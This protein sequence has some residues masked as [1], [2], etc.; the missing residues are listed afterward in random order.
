MFYNII[1]LR[2][3][4]NL[5]GYNNDLIYKIRKDMI[6]FKNITCDAPPNKINVVIMGY[7]TW[8]SLPKK[9]TPLPNRINVVLTKNHLYNLKNTVNSMDDE[10]KRLVMIRNN[11]GAVLNELEKMP[12]IHDI[13]VIGGESIFRDA[14]NMNKVKRIY[15]TEVQSNKIDEIE[16]MEDASY[17]PYL[18]LS[19]YNIINTS[20]VITVPM[21]SS[22]FE[23]DPESKKIIKKE[24][25]TN[26]DYTNVIYESK[27]YD[28]IIKSLEKDNA[29]NVQNNEEMQYLNLLKEVITIGHK[30]QTRNAITYS[31]FGKRMEFDLSDGRIPVLTTKRIAIK[32]CTKELLWF[33]SGDTN[34]N[35]LFE[36]NVHIWDG[37]SSREYLDSIGLTE[38]KEGDLGPVY[39]FQWRHSGAKYTTCDAD[40]EGQGIDQL[41]NCINLLKND[42]HSRRNILSAWNPSDMSAMALPPCHIMAQWYV[43]DGNKL[44]LQMY[45]RSGD[46]FL[47]VPFNIFSYSLLLHMMAHVCGMK[48]GR[49]IHIIGD[50]HAYDIHIDAINEQLI[51]EPQ[52]F[53]TIKFNNNI[54]NITDFKLD[55][56][57][58][59]DYKC[60]PSIKSPMIA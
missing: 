37:N 30:R 46:S 44:S 24:T 16:F 34:N 55:D 4:A 38:R 17:F 10:T 31:T 11:F 51:R 60:H 52:R 26:I 39:G 59:V 57:E 33:I 18:D 58:I 8:E 50:F 12:N 9:S 2:D 54:E 40:Y 6:N 21:N 48:P 43:E 36:Q 19:K 25:N 7:N 20:E 45:Q 47:G 13:Y 5:I 41:L 32:T 22:W 29:N 1:A 35:T 56:I 49:F 23:C 27:R 28:D 53:P 14:L 15:M 42:P 3:S